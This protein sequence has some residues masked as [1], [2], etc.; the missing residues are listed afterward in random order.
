[1]EKLWY[2][3]PATAFGQ[4]LPLGNGRMGAMVYGQI[5]QE[6]I[7]L[8]EESIYTPGPRN[9]INPHAR[10]NFEKIRELIF[11]GQIQQAESLARLAFTGIPE[12]QA[13]YQTLGE[14]TLY[15]QSSSEASGYS[16][17]LSLNDA[18]TTVEYWQ[19]GNKVTRKAFISAADQVLAMQIVSTGT[20]PDIRVQ[21]TR[22]RITNHSAAVDAKTIM[23]SGDAGNGGTSYACM[24]RALAD[25]QITVY[26][27]QLLIQNA[28]EVT[29][30]LSARTS[31]YERDPEARCLSDLE[32]AASM[33]YDTLF[34]RHL[35]EYFPYYDSMSL[36]LGEG[37]A[38]P[39]D[40]WLARLRAGEETPALY[41]LYFAYGRYLLIA[42]SRPDTLPA[43]LQGVWNNQFFPHWGSRYT[44][45]INTQMNYWPAER[46]G[47]SKLHQPLFTHLK[48]MLPNGQQ[49]AREM[50]GLDGFVAHHNTDLWGDCAPQDQYLP[51]T[52]WVLGAAWLCTHIMTHYRY[53]GDQ[54]FLQDHFELLQ[55][56]LRFLEGFLVMHQGHLVCCPSVSPENTYALPDGTHGR[57]CYG[58]SMDSQI[59]YTFFENFIEAAGVLGLEGAQVQ[60][61][62]TMLEKLPKPAI[63]PHGTLLEWA[64]DYEETELGH[65]HIS[66]LFGLYPGNLFTYEKTPELL[67][68]CRTTLVR[69][70]SNGGGHT[71]W[72]R[73]WIVG[74]YARLREGN[75]ALE[76]LA[77]LLA[78]STFDNLMDNHP[79]MPQ[80]VFQIDGNLGAIAAITEMLVYDHQGTL[81]LLPALPDAW[82]KGQLKG[83]CLEGGATLHMVWEKGQVTQAVIQCPKDY[84]AQLL[85]NGQALA[86]RAHAGK[87]FHYCAPC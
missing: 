3:K 73:A 87:P 26:G 76:N 15:F 7:G 9:R 21:L 56:T 17:S 11:A 2:K 31:F 37:V 53:T 16:R 46:C 43:T 12:G 86:V 22:G 40:E 66:H 72:S 84:A 33:G 8:N 28:R 23:M 62:K 55:E 60:S 5:Q 65:R 58:A 19:G 38:I 29:L 81:V 85:V 79:A 71:G 78:Q 64:V 30:L 10:A 63:G 13:T 57:M 69:R 1:M 47:L 4:A 44:I 68:A 35:A 49:V 54:A 39:T 45:N 27:D 14:L 32:A 6:E 52:Y 59:L 25:G 41:G 42:C 50:Y 74:F 18:Q 48:R 34:K 75:S 51:S 20:L 83:L 36:N 82:P 61:A 80:P 24:A 70:L 67:Q 77:A